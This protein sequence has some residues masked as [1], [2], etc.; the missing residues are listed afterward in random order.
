MITKPLSFQ[1]LLG[2]MALVKIAKSMDTRLHSE[3]YKNRCYLVLV[4]LETSA[5]KVQCFFC[6]A[7]LLPSD[8][9]KMMFFYKINLTH[10]DTLACKKNPSFS[11]RKA[12]I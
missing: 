3:F 6:F 4:K 5:G 12:S 8:H 1:Q 11:K 7:F 10:P 2:T 9:A